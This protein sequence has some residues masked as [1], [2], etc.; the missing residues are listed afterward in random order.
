MFFNHNSEGEIPF[1]DSIERQQG[2][3]ILKKSFIKKNDTD[4]LVVSEGDFYKEK[5]SFYKMTGKPDLDKRV[6]SFKE[7]I[8]TVLKSINTNGAYNYFLVSHSNFMQASI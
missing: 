2:I 5:L 4:S 7:G 8:G 1:L 3:Y 6:A